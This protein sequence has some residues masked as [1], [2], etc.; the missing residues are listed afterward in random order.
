MHYEDNDRRTRQRRQHNEQQQQQPGCRRRSRVVLCSAAP[1]A[2]ALVVVVFLGVALSPQPCRAFLSGGGTAGG[3]ARS[4]VASTSL[5]TRK[6]CTSLTLSRAAAT[7]TLLAKKKATK[8]STSPKGFGSG[9]AD[10]DDTFERQ[11]QEEEPST[12]A[13]TFLRS[14]ESGGSDSIP[15][16]E[17]P[18]RQARRADGGADDEL[19]LPE[20][21]AKQI[22]REKY[23]MK[24]LEEQQMDAKQVKQYEERQKKLGQWKKAAESEQELDIMA[25]IPAPIVIAIDR[26]LKIGLTV[27]GVL[28]I[29]AGLGITLEAWS[30]T[31]GNPLPPDVDAFIADTIEPNFTTGLLVL[32]GFSVSLGI[33][34]AAQLS[35][36]SAIYKEGGE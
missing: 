18:T 26:F 6:E 4:F 9:G 36:A 11:Q 30:K 15:V 1:A 33:F 29:G 28:F 5:L 23:G 17:E 21:R 3:V 10:E 7:T 2:A 25:M 35:S 12:A 20:E 13:T 22:L 24:S 34:A 19:L 31:S 16:V 27:C 14:V 8:R 32:L